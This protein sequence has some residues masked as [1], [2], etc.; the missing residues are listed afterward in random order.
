MADELDA[1]VPVR[2]RGSADHLIV[3]ALGS[4]ARLDQAAPQ[5]GVSERTVRRRMGDP[6]FR[7]AVENFQAQTMERIATEL[8]LRQRAPPSARSLSC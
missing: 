7:A 5:A 1:L 4:G 8:S 3:A 6:A 2:R